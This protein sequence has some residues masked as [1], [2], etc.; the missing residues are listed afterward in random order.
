MKQFFLF[1]YADFQKTKGLPIRKA[2]LFI[3]IGIAAIFLAY[4]SF[5]GWDSLT[6][7]S[8]YF[9]VLGIGLPC[10][11]G[12]FCAALAEQE[13]EAGGFFGLL[14]LPKKTAAFG[15]KLLLLYLAGGCSLFLASLLF[16][17]V[18]TL[19]YGKTALPVTFYFTAPLLLWGSSLFLYLM[20]FFLAIRFSGGLSAGLGITESLL[21]A[22]MLTGLGDRIWPFL[23]PAWGARLV[24]HYLLWSASSAVLPDACRTATAVCILT[25]LAAFIVCFIF[26]RHFEGRKG[27]E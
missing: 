18:Y 23:P 11:V 27:R 21:C 16:G 1:L 14:S 20:H 9:Q 15:S 6:K 17:I 8:A 22:L 3:P 25:T 7:V 26:V 2:H 13:A 24:S 5:S 12:L 10:L 4:Y 19:L